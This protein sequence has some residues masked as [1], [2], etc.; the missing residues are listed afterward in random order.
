[1]RKVLFFKRSRDMPIASHS[2]SLE[3]VGGVKNR[4]LLCCYEE[5]S[6]EGAGWQLFVK[7]SHHH[8]AETFK[9][10]GHE[11]FVLL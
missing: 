11:R 8:R 4:F 7:C 2:A 5:F 9:C 10:S 3:N 6:Y 1:M